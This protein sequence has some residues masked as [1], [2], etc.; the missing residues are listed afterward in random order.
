MDLAV[1]DYV[2]S[3]NAEHRRM[4]D[5]IHKLVMSEHPDA[6]LVLS[7]KMPTYKLGKRRLHVA[8]WQHGISL[9]GWGQGR[10]ADFVARHPSLKTSKGTIRLTPADAATVTDAE[11]LQLVR[12]A[13]NA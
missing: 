12:A 3:I 6:M 10:E 7:Y 5:R 9:Y 1:Q 11:L 13:L 4:F 8:A 2:D